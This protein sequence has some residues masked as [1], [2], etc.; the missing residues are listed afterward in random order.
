MSDSDCVGHGTRTV[1]VQVAY[2]TGTVRVQ[3]LR[4]VQFANYIVTNN[5][6]PVPRTRISVL[7]KY[8]YS[9]GTYHACTSNTEQVGYY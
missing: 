9:Y 3:V 7:Y 2:S 1:R 6:C 8:L 4:T 5:T